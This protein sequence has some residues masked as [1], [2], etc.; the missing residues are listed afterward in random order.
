M[1]TS[2]RVR[3][4]GWKTSFLRLYLH[5]KPDAIANQETRGMIRGYNRVHP[6]DS[7]T[8]IKRNLNLSPARSPTTS[9]SWS[10]RS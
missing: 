1:P 2:E 8:D 7:Y 9:T 6:G 10:G 3:N 4:W 5:L